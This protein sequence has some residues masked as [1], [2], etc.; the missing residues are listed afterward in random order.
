MGGPPPELGHSTPFRRNGQ[1]K[2]VSRPIG[3]KRAGLIPG[4]MH[5]LQFA[6]ANGVAALYITKRTCDP[7]KADDP[8][9]KLLRDLRVLTEPVADRLFCSRGDDDTDKT[10]RRAECAAKY[11]ILLLLGDQLLDFLQIPPELAISMVDRSSTKP[12]RG[13]GANAGFNSPIRRTAH[14]KELWA[15][16]SIGSCLA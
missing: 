4:A 3:P 14:G 10:G 7:T 12:M 13:C 15:I 1:P 9:V 11:R 6:H 2:I 5:F 16:P 8:R